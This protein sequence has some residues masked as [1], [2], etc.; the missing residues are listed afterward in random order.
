VKL[1]ENLPVLLQPV[2]LVGRRGLNLTLSTASPGK[3]GVLIVE[4]KHG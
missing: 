2:A 1:E 3:P 4:E